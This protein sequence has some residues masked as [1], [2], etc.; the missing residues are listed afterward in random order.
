MSE[1]SVIGLDL[2]KHV[3]QAHRADAARHLPYPDGTRAQRM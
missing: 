2:A 3:F 1:V